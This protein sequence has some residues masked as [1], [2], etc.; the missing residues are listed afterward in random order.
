MSRPATLA[1]AKTI[2]PEWEDELIE[3]AIHHNHIQVWD[4]GEVFVQDIGALGW[5]TTL[6]AAAHTVYTLDDDVDIEPNTTNDKE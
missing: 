4:D 5:L 1:E 6:Y 2:F 3:L